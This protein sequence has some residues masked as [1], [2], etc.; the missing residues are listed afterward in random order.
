M[1]AHYPPRE[2]IRQRLLR[3]RRAIDD[4]LADRHIDDLVWERLPSGEFAWL[5]PETD[6]RYVVTDQGRAAL[7]A[8]A[9]ARV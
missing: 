9:A 6:R 3:D 1:H 7:G 2:T 5:R 8:G 4:L